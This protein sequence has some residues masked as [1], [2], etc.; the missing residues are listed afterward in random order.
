VGDPLVVSRVVIVGGGIIGLCTALYCREAGFE[1]TVLEQ[2]GPDDKPCSWGNSGLI[3]PSHFVPLAAPGMVAMG[4]RM[5]PDKSSPFAFHMPPTAQQLAWSLQFAMRCKSSH[6]AASSPFLSDMNMLSRG[7]YE[8]LAGRLGGFAFRRSGMLELY[9]SQESLDHGAHVAETARNLGQDAEVLDR[10]GVHELEPDLKP[11]CI[12]GV[13]FRDDAQIDPSAVLQSVK[14]HLD[15]LGVD[16][17]LQARVVD[18]EASSDSVEAVVTEDD[19]VEADHVVVAAGTFSTDVCQALG[20]HVPLQ[21]GK[22]Y[23]FV[24]HEPPVQHK[25]PSILV[26]ARVA[27]SP[28]EGRVRFG[29]T[30]EIGGQLGEID[31]QRLGGIVKGVRRYFPAY[32][33]VEMPSGEVWEGL[34]PCSPDG[35]PTIGHVP[36]W[37]NLV[38][39]TGHAMMGMSLGP[40]TGLVVSQLLQG[41]PTTIDLRPAAPER[42]S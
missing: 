37:K 28:L 17:M 35:V 19:R 11:E 13:V 10:A 24:V 40:A 6:V 14:Q 42:F 8:G 39:A 3:V 36:G 34:R 32:E 41:L 15:S 31:A 12:G 38:L 1:V 16:I 33:N 7:L 2:G 29:G 30:M 21:S 5:L 26:D 25:M 18:F 23:S 4:L 22:G 9:Q 20:V 27:V